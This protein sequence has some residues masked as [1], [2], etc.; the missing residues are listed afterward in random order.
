MLELKKT[1]NEKAERFDV[2]IPLIPILISASCLRASVEV[3]SSFVIKSFSL[4]VN[5]LLEKKKAHPYVLASMG[6]RIKKIKVLRTTPKFS[7]NCISTKAVS[8]DVPLP[9]SSAISCESFF[10][11]CL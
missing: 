2:F 11:F 1:M 5:A 10:V 3:C 7:I 9:I 8:F 6:V 4:S